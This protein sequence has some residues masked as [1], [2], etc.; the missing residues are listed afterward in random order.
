[1]ITINEQVILFLICVKTGI[2]MG[3]FYDFVRVFRK[4]INHPNWVVQVED[5]L[6]WIACGG[7]AFSMIYWRNYGQ[8]RGF[9]FLGMIIGITLYFCTVSIFVME[10]ATK[11]IRIAKN[12]TNQMI[13]FIL[14]PIRC[15]LRIVALPINYIKNLYRMI[16]RRRALRKQQAKL[17]RKRQKA[18]LKAQIQIIKRKK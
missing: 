1:M 5:L 7:F 17:R 14:I 6:Y 13:C 16:K 18:K 3:I 11:V 8:I 10:I 2:M 15:I 9:V 4:I 12:I